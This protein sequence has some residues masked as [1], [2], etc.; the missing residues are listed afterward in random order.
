MADEKEKTIAKDQE[1][2]KPAGGKKPTDEISEED[3]K[4]AAGGG[5]L[6]DKGSP[7]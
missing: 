2:I 4:K 3:L 6:L 7:N 1:I 5:R